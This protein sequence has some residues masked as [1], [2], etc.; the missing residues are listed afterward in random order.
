MGD[1]SLRLLSGRMGDT[2]E[3]A[4]AGKRRQRGRR[5]PPG[6]ANAVRKT[7]RADSGDGASRGK[8]RLIFA[9]LAAILLVGGALRASYLREIIHSPDFAF[10]QIDAGYHDYWARGIATGDWTL[11]KNLSDWADPHI[12]SVPYLRP[13]GYPFF[14]AGVYYLSGGSYLAARVV[15]MLLGL[16][17]CVLAFSLGRRIF[18]SAVGLIFAF[19]MS[20]YGVFVYFEGELLDSMLLVTLGLSLFHVLSFWA[21]RFAFGR[22]LAGGIVLGLFALVGTNVLL[23]PPFVLGW[24]WW[25]AR[26]RQ[27]RRRLMSVGLGFIAGIVVTIAPVTIRNWIVSKDFVPVAANVGISLYTGNHEGADGGFAIIPDLKEL[28]AGDS[29]TCFDY[30]KMVQGVERKIGHKVKYSEVSSYFVGRAMEFMRAHPARA[31]K[32]VAG[33]TARFWGPQESD[34]NKN[35]DLEMAHSVT[36]RH[37]PGFPLPLS[38][39][40]F[41]LI[42]LFL[43]RRTRSDEDEAPSPESDRRFELSVLIV[44]FILVYFVSYLPFFVVGRYRIPV[45]PFLFLFGAYGLQRVGQ[46]L[47]ATRYRAAAGWLALLAVLYAAAGVRLVPHEPSQAPWH[48]LRASCYRLA[49]KPDMAVA[50]CRAAIAADPTS[51]EGHRRLGDMLYA[52]NDYPEA[53]EHYA[54]AVALRPDY[55]QARYNLASSLVPLQKYDE[56]IV[57]LRWV[58]GHYANLPSAHY[59]LAR[60]LKTTGSAGE[61]AEQYRRA[62]ALQPDYYRAHNNLANILLEEGKV[63]EAIEHYRLAL[64]ARP[65]YDA[66]Q[67]NLSRALLLKGGSK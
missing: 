60:T 21:D 67:Q 23:F 50:E 40:V 4:M 30:P 64:K 3:L 44:A 63:D 45:I 55:M 58:V 32:L 6:D 42:R 11:P 17:N 57:Q 41:G 38:L 9:A 51:A 22:G 61:A 53:A 39:G 27:D 15:Q 46:G 24:S 29:W 48:L 66:A 18:G 5:V 26:R 36:L 25:V 1:A 8:A 52:R 56:A 33:K 37:L 12:R 31:L 13:P 59:L 34:N 14:L 65:D 2:R 20:S 10:P 54:R 62:I 28:G 47:M 43:T 35:T 16:A 7:V 49:E 19:L